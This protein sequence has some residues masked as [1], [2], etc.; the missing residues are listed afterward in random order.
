MAS[1]C[2]SLY[3]DNM[4]KEELYDAL[5]NIIT[6]GIDTDILAGWGAIVYILSDQGIEAK[7]IKT[8]MI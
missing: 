1:L 6:A 2:E 3:K 8:K 5:S 7:Y 4:N